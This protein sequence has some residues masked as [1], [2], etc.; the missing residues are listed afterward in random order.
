VVQFD[1]RNIQHDKE[2]NLH[3][4]DS[5]LAFDPTKVS[6]S[7]RSAVQD[8]IARIAPVDT[9]NKVTVSRRSLWPPYSA[10][11]VRRKKR[12]ASPPDIISTIS[13]ANRLDPSEKVESGTTLLLP[14]SPTLGETKQEVKLTKILDLDSFRS[15]GLK[16][17]LTE[18]TT[19][20]AN[21]KKVTTIW[22]FS[23]PVESLNTLVASLLATARDEINRAL[24]EIARGPIRL[25][26]LGAL[27]PSAAKK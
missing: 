25:S 27:C 11:C 21:R 2:H 1:G 20:Q 3:A 13:G 16:G 8:F 4:G 5:V 10:R 18:L 17:D 24:E 23:A 6:P 9:W 19:T 7:T 26:Q 14:P 15:I 22:A 12:T